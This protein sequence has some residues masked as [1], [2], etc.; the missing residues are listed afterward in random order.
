MFIHVYICL[1]CPMYA[2]IFAVKTQRHSIHTHVYI[3][4]HTY[5][6]THTYIHIGGSSV[7]PSIYKTK[8][9]LSHWSNQVCSVLKL[10]TG[11]QRSIG[12]LK[13]QVSFCKRATIYRACLRKMTYENKAL[14][15][16]WPP[17]I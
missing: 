16:S 2:E 1:W 12:C 10:N 5:I 11:W 14:Y 3:C 6:H 17:C 13:L 4:M 8:G 7:S 15:V 9:D